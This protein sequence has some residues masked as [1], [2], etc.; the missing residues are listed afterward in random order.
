VNGLLVTLDN[1]LQGAGTAGSHTPG[2]MAKILATI[3]LILEAMGVDWQQHAVFGDI[4]SG[5]GLALL[6]ALGV[7]FPIALGIEMGVGADEQLNLALAHLR[8]ASLIRQTAICDVMWGTMMGRPN[9]ATV[10]DMGRTR[11][12]SRPRA[13]R[14]YAMESRGVFGN[15]FNVVLGCDTVKAVFA[16]DAVFVADAKATLREFVCGDAAIRVFVTGVHKGKPSALEDACA[17]L[18]GSFQLIT[19]LDGSMKGS[20]SEGFDML[21]FARL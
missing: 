3:T 13:V 11:R 7:G 20:S 17:G 18:R 8:A 1:G 14:D 10:V 5:V 2:S 9:G 21:V 4:G 19:K 12:S 15:C 6:G 16:F